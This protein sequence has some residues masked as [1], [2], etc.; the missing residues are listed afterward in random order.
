MRSEAG[1]WSPLCGAVTQI[2]AA[3]ELMTRDAVFALT[4]EDRFSFRRFEGVGIDR[5]SAPVWVAAHSWASCFSS[6]KHHSAAGMFPRE[7]GH[8][9]A[10]HDSLQGLEV[11]PKYKLTTFFC[12]HLL[13]D[14]CIFVF[15]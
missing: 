10:F 4:D 14:D 11:R 8:D 7:V 2:T 5:R 15:I 1:G 12:Q 3:D 13:V 6:L 9:H